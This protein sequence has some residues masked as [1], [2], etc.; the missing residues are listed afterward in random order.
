MAYQPLMSGIIM[1][2]GGENRQVFFDMKALASYK[3]GG[4]SVETSS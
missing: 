2:S 1:E 4:S 3:S